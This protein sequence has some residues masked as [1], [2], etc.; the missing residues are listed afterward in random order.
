MRRVV[1]S[2][3]VLVA[4]V[5]LVPRASYAQAA[6]AGVVKDA[7]GAVMPGVLVEA[8]SPALIERTRSVTTDSA[9]QYKIVDLRPGTYEVAFTLAGFKTVRRGNVLLEGNFTPTVNAELQV[10]AL[11]EVLT[12]T[13]ESPVVDVVN[14]Q[15]TFVA[16]RE[17]LDAIPTTDRSTTSRALLIPGTTVTP[18]VLGQ[19]NLTSHGSSTS[20]FTIAI[21]GLRVNNLCGSGQ[22]SGFYM[23]DASVQELTY[24]T[25]SESAEIQSS[26][27]R[28]NSV[29]K[30]GGNKFSGS[31]FLYGQGSSLQ[32]DNRTDAVK[33]AGITI[34][35]TAYDW[36]INPS[37]GGPLA[38]DKI[39]FYATYKYQDNKFYVPSSHFA[40]GSPAYRNNMG[41]YSGVGRVTWAA[42]SK[43]KI[44]VYVEKQFNGEFFNGFNTYAVTTPEASTD[45]FGR[46]WI[47]QIRWTRAQS[48]KLL[49]DAGISYYNQPYE[50]NCRASVKPT[51]LPV[52][53]GST[54][55]LT[56][57]CGYTI[58]PYKSTT[59]D[60]SMMASASYVTGSHAIKVGMTDGWGENSRTFSPNANIDALIKINVAGLGNE[61]PF[62]A[63]VYNSPATAIQNVNSDFGSYVQDTWTMKKLTLNYGGRFEHFNASIPAESSAGSTWIGARNFPEIPNVP[64]WNDWAVRFAAAYDL[65]GDGK[66]A[67]KASAGKY[68]ASQAAG[69]AQNFNGMSGTTQT[70]TWTDL[71]RNGT[72]LDA[73]GNIEVNE[74][75]ARTPNFGQVTVRPDPAL[76]RGYNWEYTAQLQRELMPRTSVTV[77][78]YHRDFYNLQVVDNQ[79]LSTADWAALSITTPTDPRLPLSGQPIPLYTLSPTKV[80]IATDNLYT[81]STQNKSAYNGFE[82]SANIRRDKFILFGGVTT[83]RLK[84]S[85]CDGSTATFDVGARG[86][87]ARDNPN[88]LRFCDVTLATAGQPAGVFRTT[89]KASAAYSF[90]YDIQLSGSFASIPGPGIRADYTVT[91]AL[92]GRPIIGSTT[93][94]ASTIVNLVEP[95][96]VFL[97]YQNRL[98]MRV[99]KTFRLDRTRIQGFADVFN[100]LNAGSVMTVN[101]TYGAVAA[102]NAWLTPTTIMQGR[103]VRFGM[104]L[105]F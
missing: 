20:D 55:L 103:F 66:T 94:A 17:I 64:N 7:S 104:Q 69:Y 46:G 78:F 33:A 65:S 91:S 70:V 15:Q 50:Q 96:S 30:D 36:Q 79:N 89:V 12:V 54:G 92:A 83:D 56:G 98:D 81:Y 57:A 88:S 99:G 35:G 75:G 18:F 60:Y 1:L 100:V 97:P 53:N 44:R 37:F 24:S 68:V 58:P 29:P 19:F 40:D 67:F 49:L 26:G 80:G 47:P 25:G 43:D 23:N 32:A 6:I 105:N 82:V 27:I 38:K 62:Q 85:N 77:A 22:Y 52:L 101:Q 16:N 72:I 41:S 59:K 14:N 74:V 28:V 51:D 10:G 39:W 87:S 71:D 73:A 3:A 61:I 48:N 31:F 45:A 42:S 84:T 90:P 95:N 34:A 9:G 102:T 13:A 93:G 5:F 76:A 21:D 8:S 63:V 11:T 86:A 4:A 2:M